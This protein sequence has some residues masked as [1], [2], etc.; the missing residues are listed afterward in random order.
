MAVTAL[1]VVIFILDLVTGGIIRRNV[2]SLAI[3]V[4]RISTGMWTTVFANG[5]FSSRATLQ[6]T[7]QSQREEIARLQEAAATYNLMKQENDQLRTL[8]AIAERSPGITAPIISSFTS[9]PYGT[10]MIGAGTAD[11]IGT[12]NL[13]I[14]PGGFA[15]GRV[16]EQGEHSSLITQLFAPG[17]SIDALIGSA[18]VVVEGSGGQ[19]A[20]TRIAH[21][22]TVK[23]GDPVTAPALRGREI[24][25]VAKVD[26]TA[27]GAYSN[28]DIGLPTN[29]TGLQF[30]YVEK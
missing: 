28:V 18:P 2:R 13:V 7:I 29:L 27:G 12:G 5:F 11:G 14:S 10:F 15:I 20:K 4:I 8:V 19:N 17:T 24:G 1:V 22:I 16:S 23:E 21:G 6:K 25:I 26:E 30:V 9:S 3:P